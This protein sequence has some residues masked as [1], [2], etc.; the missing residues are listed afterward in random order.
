M[1]GVLLW[2][3]VVMHALF[4]M[5]GCVVLVCCCILSSFN[6]WFCLCIFGTVV[7]V[8]KVLVVQYFLAYLV[9]FVLLFD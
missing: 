8:L 7:N 3:A 6:K 1:Q 5:V 9:G 4:R 2:L